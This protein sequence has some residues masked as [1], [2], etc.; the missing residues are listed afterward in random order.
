MDFIRQAA[1]KKVIRTTQYGDQEFTRWELEI[2]HT[3]IVQRLYNLKQLGFTDRVYPDAVHSRFNHVLGAT[4]MA[5]R[6]ARRLQIW[7]GEQAE[8]KFKYAVPVD[9]NFDEHEVTGR[10]LG[11]Q[12]GDRIPVVR[13]VALLH[14]LTHAAFGHTLEDEVCLFQEKHDS[15]ER[16]QRFFNALV[17]QLVYIWTTE[18]GIRDADPRVFDDLGNLVVDSSVVARWSDEIAEHL[19]PSGENHGLASL[20][21]QME[22]AMVLLAHIEFLHDRGQSMPAVPVLLVRDI[23]QRISKTVPAVEFHLH[24]DAYLVDMVG[25]TICADLLDYARRDAANAGLKV[26]FDERLIRYLSVVSV[27]GDLSPTDQPCLRLAIQFFTDKMRHDVLSEMSAVLKARYLINERV[28]F[29]PTKC[30]AGA[31]LG[32]AVQLLGLA[33]LPPWM[34]ALGDQE[35]LAQ[36]KDIGEALATVFSL[37]T[38][39]SGKR[40]TDLNSNLS[41]SPKLTS[42]VR[43][44]LDHI[45]ETE[46]I[47]PTVVS[48]QVRRLEERIVGARCLL[49]RISGRRY[50][51]L[52]YRLRPGLHHSGGESDDT[53][54]K[55]YSEPENRYKLEREIERNCHLP[56]GSIV[57][58]CPRRQTSMKVAEV[59]VVGSELSRVAKLRDV[60]TV[61]PESLEPYQEEIRAI[62][63]MYRSIWAVSRLLGLCQI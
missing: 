20:L 45:F 10:E 47:G 11:A 31:M 40:W 16:Q 42:V 4:E 41:C 17:A 5:E 61:S 36:L 51:K 63:S 55:R 59:L 49:W 56:V 52:A 24:R 44:A 29:H 48:E 43:D 53:M 2:I 33:S 8:T 58:H 6:M 25:N 28:L 34:Q 22:L 37:A 32:T 15:Q 23:A 35:F 1:K 7:L 60:I 38:G 13:L 50:P 9:A 27:N 30:A 26:Q 62:E 12:L 21:R 14:D 3:P 18:L 57:I 39:S 46:H 19:A 54:A